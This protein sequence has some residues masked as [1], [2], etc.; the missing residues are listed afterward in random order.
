MASTTLLRTDNVCLLL[1]AL[2]QVPRVPA[3]PWAMAD[4]MSYVA[5]HANEAGPL[6]PPMKIIRQRSRMT[7]QL[8]R[9]AI[10]EL[11]A[12]GSFVV[13]GAGWH[14]GYEVTESAKESAKQLFDTLSAEDQRVLTAAV[15]RLVAMATI[16]SKNVCVAGSARLVT[17]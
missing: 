5:R 15:Q 13:C 11:V 1:A 12:A 16:W 10:Q 14:A 2:A 6:G 8:V 9:E 17:G 3:Q 7:D 4:A